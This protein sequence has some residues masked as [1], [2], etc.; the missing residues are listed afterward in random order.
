ML[1]RT[2]VSKKCTRIY[3]HLRLDVLRE[4]LRAYLEAVYNHKATGGVKAAVGGASSDRTRLASLEREKQIAA[5][6][7]YTRYSTVYAPSSYILLPTI[8]IN[9]TKESCEG[10]Q[11]AP[12][13]SDIS[14]VPAEDQPLS[15]PTV[16][17]RS[18]RKQRVSYSMSNL[19]RGN[20]D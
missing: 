20:N 11:N 5:K 17:A 14:L 1:S 18:S 13:I 3:W 19:A 2:P 6:R 9:V 4:A 12:R 15:R 7:G 8:R 16:L 10:K